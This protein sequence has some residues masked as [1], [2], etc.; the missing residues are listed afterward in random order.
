[1]TFSKV[2][3]PTVVTLIPIMPNRH[4][5]GSNYKQVVLALAGDASYG[6]SGS[7]GWQTVDRPK[8]VAATQWMDRAP[9]Q[10]EFDAMLDHTL[11]KSIQSNPGLSQ[12]ISGRFSVEQDCSQLEMW[13]DKVPGTLLPPVFHI[14]GPV[15]GSEKIWV[16]S[17]L[18]FK[19]ALR[20]NTGG[21][22]YQ[23]HVHI[24]LMEYTA[25]LQNVYGNYNVSPTNTFKDTFSNTGS[26]ALARYY[27]KQ[28]DTMASIAAYWG[29]A[30]K[31][32]ANKIASFNNIQDPR[33]IVPGQVL[34]I[35]RPFNNA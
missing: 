22:R 14:S 23:Q 33:S 18:A 17:S 10:M 2:S 15:P 13:L 12:P 20:N 26:Q 25:P 19:E 35:P 29:N 16:M 4:H 8:L 3:S 24:T 28:G 5:G 32:F 1:M 7:G 6:P 9:F 27:V 34:I 11:T 30:T 31:G 21:F